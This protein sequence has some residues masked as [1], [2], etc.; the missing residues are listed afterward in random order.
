MIKV[1]SP[2]TTLYS[3]ATHNISIL[4]QATEAGK[5]RDE[6]RRFSTRPVCFVIAKCRRGKQASQR[7]NDQHNYHK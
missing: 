2:L 7:T 4:T 3:C 1:R 5:F 6:Y